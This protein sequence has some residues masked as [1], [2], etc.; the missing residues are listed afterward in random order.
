MELQGEPDE[1]GLPV[2]K[3]YA[4]PGQHRIVFRKAI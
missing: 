3:D 4:G 2:V 1:N